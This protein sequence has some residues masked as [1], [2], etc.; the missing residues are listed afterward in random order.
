MDITINGKNAIWKGYGFMQ[1]KLEQ[2]LEE[3]LTYE[4]CL[5]LEIQ[6]F[7]EHIQDTHALSLDLEAASATQGDD[8][9]W[10]LTM[11][12]I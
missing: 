7:T 6:A 3:G 11:P 5:S 12:I 1:D 4:E 10:T 9:I 2:G 8:G